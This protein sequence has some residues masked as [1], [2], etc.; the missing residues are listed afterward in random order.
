VDVGAGVAHLLPNL[1]TALPG[2]A[3]AVDGGQ[4]EACAMLV[5]QK[6]GLN[7]VLWNL[8]KNAHDGDG[9]RRA[10]LVRVAV[11]VLPRE[12]GLVVEDD[13]PGFQDL[14][15]VGAVKPGGLGVGLESVRTIV[16]ASGGRLELG[17]STLGGARVRV[18]LP[19]A[20]STATRLPA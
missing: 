16:E 20:P 6:R 9:R 8:L 12:V 18:S 19:C 13:G 10:T 1:A 3:I 14:P 4:S 5:G 15:G 7:R 2:L 11:E 17:R